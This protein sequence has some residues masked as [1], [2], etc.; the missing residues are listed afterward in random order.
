MK[1][2]TFSVP[3]QDGLRRWA[4]DALLDEMA[5][6]GIAIEQWAWATFLLR[7]TFDDPAWFPH[8]KWAT[9]QFLENE[10]M[11]EAA[12]Q[13]R[14]RAAKAVKREETWKSNR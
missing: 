7:A 3:A 11:A 6:E 14:G 8:G 12:A 2:D 9:I 1:L 10:P 13:L 5:L 4:K